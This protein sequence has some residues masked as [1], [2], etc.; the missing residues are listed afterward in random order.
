[1]RICLLFLLFLGFSSVAR[2]Q[3]VQTT[4]ILR[5]A[6]GRAGSRYNLLEVLQTRGKTIFPDILYIDFGRGNE[7]REVG[8]GFGRILYSSERHLL[9]G[10]LYFFA[11]TG[12][13]ANGA[14]YLQPWVYAKYGFTEKLSL[15]ASYFP[16]IPVNSAGTVQHVLEH[17]KLERRVKKVW[18][19][20]GYEGYKFG[21]QDWQNF[22]FG[23]AAFTVPKFGNMEVWGQHVPGGFR[24]QLRYDKTWK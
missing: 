20:V 2:A 11:A 19:G 15:Q 8:L 5:T 18:L 1:M 12:P 23:S 16:Y 10:E 14:L 9:I 7:Y 13:A 22:P 3:E 4:L 6:I 24:V 21:E 17:I